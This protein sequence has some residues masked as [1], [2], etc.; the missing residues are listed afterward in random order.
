MLVPM[1]LVLAAGLGAGC[2]GFP[3]GKLPT[4]SIDTVS[5]ISLPP[6]VSLRTYAAPV[7]DRSSSPPT[8]LVVSTHTSTPVGQHVFLL[9]DV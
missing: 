5:L 1:L 9:V 4:A 6:Y 8:A 3:S 2:Y 7:R